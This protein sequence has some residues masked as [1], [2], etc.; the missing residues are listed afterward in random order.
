MEK[1]FTENNNEPLK[2]IQIFNWICI[3]FQIWRNFVKVAIKFGKI[4]A[5]FYLPSALS[6]FKRYLQEISGKF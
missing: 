3:K 1:K 2:S 6:N 4:L 5:K